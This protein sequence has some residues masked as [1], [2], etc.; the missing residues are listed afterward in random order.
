[1]LHLGSELLVE[2]VSGNVSQISLQ[3]NIGH[4]PKVLVFDKI[5]QCLM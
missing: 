3:I 5:I 2:I 1:M 4:R